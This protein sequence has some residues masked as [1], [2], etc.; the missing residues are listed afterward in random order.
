MA[1]SL[2][3]ARALGHVRRLG[4]YGGSFD[5]VHVGH[6]HVARVAQRAFALE[7]VVFVPAAEPPHKPGRKLASREDR[8]RMLELALADEPR[9]SISTLEFERAG[10]SFTVDTLRALPQRLALAPEAEL[11]LLIGWDNLRGL[12]R[13]RSVRELLALAQ[14][15]VVWRA[16][17]DESLLDSLRRELGPELY[18]NIA[19]GL[20]REPPAPES[21][22]ELRATLARGGEPLDALPAGVLEYI[23]SRGIYR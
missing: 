20:V 15:V 4:V 2:R 12:E 16:G 9:W 10:P 18:A 3:E 8:V 19:R 23:R 5:P 11:Y 13:W 22:T 21:S 1:E 6:L 17:A 14:L 7:H